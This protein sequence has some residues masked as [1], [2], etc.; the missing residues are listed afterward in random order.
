MATVNIITAYNL[1]EAADKVG[2]SR[3]T[4]WR[5]LRDGKLTATRRGREMLITSDDL[6]EYV[7]REQ[8][9]RG[10]PRE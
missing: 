5:H 7:L 6:L 2:V 3:V 10:L 8:G 9:G 1:T 4:L